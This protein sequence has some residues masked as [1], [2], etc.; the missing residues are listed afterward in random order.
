[1][2]QSDAE[3][4]TFDVMKDKLA[5]SAM[6][7]SGPPPQAPLGLSSDILRVLLVPVRRVLYWSYW[8]HTGGSGR[9]V[10]GAIPIQPKMLGASAAVASLPSE[11]ME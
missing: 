11:T 3:Q 5:T 9:I 1:M 6:K 10:T 7:Y 8:Y 2:E 4:R